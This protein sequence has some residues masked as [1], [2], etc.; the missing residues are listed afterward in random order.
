MKSGM[1]Q[2]FAA[3]ICPVDRDGLRY[4]VLQLFSGE[5][6][7]AASPAGHAPSP[8]PVPAAAPPAVPAPPPAP[9]VA[10]ATPAPAIPAPPAPPVTDLTATASPPTE[11]ATA[12]KKKLDSALQLTRSVALDFNNALTSIL[13]HTSL[14]LSKM[15]PAHPWRNSLLE[16]EKAADKAAEISNALSEFSRQER[17]TRAHAEGNLND[18]LRRAVELFKS[19]APKDR[20]WKLHLEGKLFAARFDEAKLQQAIL[21]ILENA[22]EAVAEGGRVT[23]LSRNR[24]VTEPTTDGT[25]KLAVGSY[26]CAEVSDNGAGIT[27]ESLPRIFEP[28]FTTKTGHR[29]LGLAW[30]YGIITNHGGAVAVTSQPGSGTTFRIYLPAQKRIVK[31]RTYKDDEL[32]GRETVLIVDD[33]DLL[34]TMGQMILSSYGY[35]VL[36][37]N[38][39][40][41]ALEIVQAGTERIDLV[42]TD[43]VMP[44]MSGRELID[45]LKTAAPGVPI[46]CMTGYTR[47]GRQETGYHLQ[48]PFTSQSLLAKVKEVLS[49]AEI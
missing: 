11:D 25:T 1:N 20:D 32:R 7:P 8:T 18:L 47:S 27:P 21:K 35:K 43:L 46:I 10:P 12:H 15:E 29:G 33:E 34:L 31:D 48:K 26:V 19:S 36:T 14:V 6:S 28:F 49:H 4:F 45:H 9:A 42:L 44:N 2:S 22:S 41:K 38:D 37:A 40:Q 30:V 5:G 13:G 17:D 39:G 16:V 24:E 3:Q 23:V